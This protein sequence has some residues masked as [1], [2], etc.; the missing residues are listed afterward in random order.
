[1]NE[2]VESTVRVRWLVGADGGRSFVRRALG[3]DFPGKT[4]GVR[5]IVADVQLTG[6]Q[7]DAWHRFGDGDTARQIAI[8]PLAGTDMFQIQAPVPFG[9]EVDLSAAGLNALLAARTATTLSFGRCHGHLC[10]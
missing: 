1:M 7:R 4:L 8:A 2:L 9:G 10:T 6:L 3:I 5:A